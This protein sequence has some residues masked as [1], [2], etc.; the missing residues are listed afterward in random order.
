MCTFPQPVRLYQFVKRIAQEFLDFNTSEENFFSRFGLQ[1]CTH[2]HIMS[3][4]IFSF[5]C[6]ILDAERPKAPWFMNG[7][8][9]RQPQEQ[10][11]Q[12][13]L[14]VYGYMSPDTVEGGREWEGSI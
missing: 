5:N 10:I 3:A 2:F 11:N 8:T 13:T 4:C 1:K 9:L 12:F 14:F 6:R 7:L